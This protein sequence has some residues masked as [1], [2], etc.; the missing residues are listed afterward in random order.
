MRRIA[1]SGGI[2]SRGG[3]VGRSGRQRR[4][5]LVFGDVLFAF[6]LF[7]GAPELLFDARGGFLE[8]THR[9]AEPAGKLRQLVAAEQHEHQD[10]DQQHLRSSESV[11]EGQRCAQHVHG[12]NVTHLREKDRAKSARV[13]AR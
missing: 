7:Q 3:S 11:D 9:L 2:W 1:G 6:V 4:G 10:E 5:R 13:I 12:W 8:F